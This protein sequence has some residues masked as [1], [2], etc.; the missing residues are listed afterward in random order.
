LESAGG[1]ERPVHTEKRRD[2]RKKKN[3]VDATSQ[4]GAKEMGKTP[5]AKQNRKEELKKKR[6]G[7]VDPVGRGRRSPHSGPEKGLERVSKMLGRMG[8]SEGGK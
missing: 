7:P 8:K 6:R 3:R 2:G 1:G 4:K 5:A